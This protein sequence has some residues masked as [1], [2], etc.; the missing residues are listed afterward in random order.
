MDR[1]ARGL[2]RAAALGICLAASA[3]TAFAADPAAAAQP[4]KWVTRDLDYTYQGFTTQYTC[5]GLRS[6]VVTILR[7]LGA[8]RTDLKVRITPCA[9]LGSSDL[10]FSP[11]VRGTLSVL[12]P[13]TAEEVSRGDPDIVAAHW[14]TVDL[15]R[16]RDLVTRQNGQCELLEQSRRLLVPL[17]TTRN[18]Q[19]SSNCVPHETFA[20]GMTFKVDVLQVDPQPAVH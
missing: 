3:G 10:S 2:A 4:A 17:F 11:G 19:F 16:D 15:M 6:S 5:D 9:A 14:R 8:R 7:A 12:V 20:G 1:F 18:V 13:A